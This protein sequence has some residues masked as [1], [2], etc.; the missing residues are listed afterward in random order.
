MFDGPSSPVTQTFGLGMFAPPTADDFATLESFFRERGAPV[1]HEVSPLA[2]PATLTLLNERGYRP[3]EFTNVMYQPIDVGPAEAGH[4]RS[5]ATG[6]SVVSGLSRTVS[7]RV[8]E[9]PESEVW[10]HT[11]AEGWGMPPSGFML[12]VA[13][14]NAEAPDGH[15]FLAERDGRP[16]G[17][18]VLA[19][20][21]QVAHFAG[22]RRRGAPAV[23]PCRAPT[24]SCNYATAVPLSYSSSEPVPRESAAALSSWRDR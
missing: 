24:E 13:R 8:I 16:I 6:V 12:D 19:I 22:A 23:H 5:Q 2:D 14:V 3:I 9:P 1:D 21:G 7:V 18:A 4:Y 10:A 17:T 20:H 11:A 15:L